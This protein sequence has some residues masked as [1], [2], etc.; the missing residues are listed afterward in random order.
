MVRLA[1]ALGIAGLL[2]CVPLPVRLAPEAR[3]V[4]VDAGTGAPLPQS[5]V[6]LRF[7][8]RYDEVLPER[9]PLGQREALSS[10]DGSFHAPGVVRA[11]FQAWPWLISRVRVV[12]V[13]RR[14]YRCP[15]PRN[16][17]AGREVRIELQ[18]AV[19]G[20]DQRASCEAVAELW[21]LAGTSTEVRR[22]LARMGLAGPT[23]AHL[24]GDDERTLAARAAL[25]FGANCQ[26]PIRDLA[27][28][29]DGARAAFLAESRSGF[30]VFVTRLESGIPEPE[31]VARSV[32]AED[33]ELVWTQAAEI[34]LLGPEE[35]DTPA[36]LD[37]VWSPPTPPAARAS[38][39]HATLDAAAPI[40]PDARNDEGDARWLGRSFSM[41]R[42][43]D[44][45]TGL[46]RDILQ[47]TLPDGA[48]EAL[49]LPG[50]ACAVR[51]RFG[52]PHYR[53]SADGR[54]GLDLRFVDGGCHVVRV[55]LANGAW[56]RLDAVAGPATC[57]EH[58]RIP[59]SQIGFA[60]RDYVRDVTE[61]LESADVDPTTAYTLVIGSSGSASIETRT[62]EGEA[63][64][65]AAPP[66]PITTPLRR[67]EVSLVGPTP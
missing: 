33:R 31:R 10:G 9:I 4:V 12:T 42:D 17:A 50:E 46:P 36:S 6:L 45:A 16:L 64:H 52:R 32:S 56:S 3:G 11:G 15:Q 20:L 5:L 24:G 14:G 61:R 13:L 18:A 29:P 43:L 62:R 26:G 22:A 34:A 58:R 67:I 47:V 48:S 7:E 54:F 40:D 44:P 41:A 23:T 25:G 65:V 21:E 66:F 55:D 19:S 1:L 8:A 28:S 2:G 51:G 53:I 37:V 59:P 39:A 57:R 63:R 49:L 27:L 30:D 35:L 60:V 38:D